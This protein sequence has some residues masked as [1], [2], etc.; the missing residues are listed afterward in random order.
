MFNN[1][2]IIGAVGSIAKLELADVDRTIAVILR[3]RCSA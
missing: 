1:A 2:G 3:G